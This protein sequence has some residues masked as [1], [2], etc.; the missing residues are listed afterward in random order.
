MS[1]RR[2]RLRRSPAL[3]LVSAGVL[4]VGAAAAWPQPPL[5]ALDLSVTEADIAPQVRVRDYDNRRV[6]EYSVNNNVYMVKI[7]PSAGAPYYLVDND[8]SGDMEWNRG[9][10]GRDMDVPQWTLMSW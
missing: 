9:Q 8:G 10:A 1:M 3:R 5:S 7:T 6:E 4:T 2:Q